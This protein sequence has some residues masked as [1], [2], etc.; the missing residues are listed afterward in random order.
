MNLMNEITFLFSQMNTVL[1][2]GA[3]PRSE[4][5]TS[6]SDPENS[7]VELLR[8]AR[9]LNMTVSRVTHLVVIPTRF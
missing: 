7:T 4:M 6:F 5:S 1:T 2:D 9:K 8:C 3:Y